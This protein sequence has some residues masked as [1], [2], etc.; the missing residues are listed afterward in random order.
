MVSP[1]LFL[2]QRCDTGLAAFPQVVA[3]GCRER[4]GFGGACRLRDGRGRC[5]SRRGGCQY[6]AQQVQQPGARLL[7]VAPVIAQH[8]ADNET[9]II[10]PWGMVVR[11]GGGCEGGRHTTMRLIHPAVWLVAQHFKLP[12]QAFADL[13]CP[14]L[15]LAPVAGLNAQA[16]GKS[17]F[18]A[19][20]GR[21]VRVF[22]GVVDKLIE[23]RK[24]VVQ[25][26]LRQVNCGCH[27]A[28]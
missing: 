9:F 8:Q 10:V 23:Q 15:D 14:A 17:A 5:G 7:G 27:C 4:T 1:L 28:G 11:R 16:F 21:G 25:T 22:D 18:Q 12:G 3:C 24:R 20:L 2:S 26:Y 6:F 19:A 13:A